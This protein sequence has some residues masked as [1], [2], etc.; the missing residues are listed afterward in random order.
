[1]GPSAWPPGARRWPCARP[2]S[3]PA[4]AR[5]PPG[6]RGGARR[7]AHAR[8]TRTPTSPLDQIGGQ[9][10]FVDRGASWRSPTGGPT[11][12]CTR[13]RTC[14]RRCRR[15]SS[16]ARV[17][18]RADP[19]DGLVGCTLAGL[20]AGRP[21]GHGLGPAAGPAGLAPPGSRLHAAAGEHG[22]AGWPS[23]EDGSVS[24]VVVAVAA[25]ERLGWADRV[26]RRA[27]PARRAAPGRAGR[28]GR[29]VPGRRRGRA[30]AAGRRS[31]TDRATGPSWPSGRCW[32]TLGGSCTV[33]VGAFA[34]PAGGGRRA[35]VV[36][37]AA[38]ERRRAHARPRWPAGR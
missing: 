2:R 38:G 15:T 17:P 5:G 23:G 25:M 6:T 20:P 28:R 35:L 16:S 11:P 26:A 7:G 8:A 34:E 27:R 18:P 32:P 13:P 37:R 31:T 3:S 12:P 29:A 14:P 21:R 36:G 1:M 30:R 22:R 24:A 19:R 33:P 10:V 4:P 9:G